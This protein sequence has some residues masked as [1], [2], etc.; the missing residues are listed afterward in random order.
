ME[1][2][3]RF[4]QIFSRLGVDA[5]KGIL[6]HGPPGSGKTLIARAVAQETQTQFYHINGPEI[7]QRHYGKARKNFALFLKK[8]RKMPRPLS[9][10][11]K[12]TPWLP[13][14]KKR[15]GEVEK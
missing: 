15:K 2:P 3:L 11:T 4:P 13:E 6:L 10:W 12:S 9:F 8:P 5:P 7:M 1:L 14:E